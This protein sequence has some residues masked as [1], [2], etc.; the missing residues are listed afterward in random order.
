MPEGDTIHRTAATLSTVIAD[1]VLTRFE[2]AGRASL[3]ALRLLRRASGSGRSK[4]A[5]STC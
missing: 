5:A 3:R 2:L 4:P 1:D